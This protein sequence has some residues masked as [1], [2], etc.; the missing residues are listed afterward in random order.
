MDIL[1]TKTYQ[2]KIFSIKHRDPSNLGGS[3]SF[4]FDRIFGIESTQREIYEEVGK[5][6]VGSS[7]V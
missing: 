5:G 6:L 7:W 4:T 1:D 3:L 2:L